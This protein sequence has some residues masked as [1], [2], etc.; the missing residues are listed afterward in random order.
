MT[1]FTRFSACIAIVITISASPLQ[2]ETSAFD[3]FVGGGIAGAG[4]NFYIS[5]NR[6]GVLKVRRAGLPMIEPGKLTEKSATIRIKPSQA[7]A[8]LRLAENA[9]DFS[10]GCHPVSDGTSAKLSLETASG[11]VERNC[12]STGTWPNGRKTKSFLGKL[13]SVLPQEFQ[14]Y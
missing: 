7:K 8:I 2:A 9:K 12:F 3:L 11:V 13:N 5:L 1:A 4:P 6:D 10:E 14:V